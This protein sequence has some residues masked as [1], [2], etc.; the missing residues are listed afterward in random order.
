M[1]FPPQPEEFII[2]PAC[3]AAGLKINVQFIVI[4]IWV[5]ICP[6]QKA[7]TERARERKR[8]GERCLRLAIKN[9]RAKRGHSPSTATISRQVVNASAER[10]KF[11][12]IRVK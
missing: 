10:Q 3:Q 12:A 1:F 4:D 6:A 7:E 8:E 11:T 5:K 2:S 9:L